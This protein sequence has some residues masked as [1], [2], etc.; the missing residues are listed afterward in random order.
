[1]SI[2][3][4]QRAPS[5]LHLA[6]NLGNSATETANN[7]MRLK[8][9]RPPSITPSIRI[10]AEALLTDRMTLEE[11][12]TQAKLIKYKVVRNAVLEVLPLLQEFSETHE[13]TWF[14]KASKYPFRITKGIDVPVQPLGFGRIDGKV[15]AV[16]SP[17]WKNIAHSVN[18]F[19]TAITLIQRGYIDQMDGDIEAF[20][21]L[22]TTQTTESR[23]RE[24]AVRDHATADQLT[25]LEYYGMVQNLIDAIAIVKAEWTPKRN[26]IQPTDEP[27]PFGF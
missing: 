24:L 8:D 2:N 23:G 20:L 7:V 3:E 25:E 6:Y 27:N 15:Q 12:E 26:K 17:F 1:M 4:I 11:L 19:R 16:F 18:Q 22:E 9:A 13:I 10:Y 14:K 21:W 5:A